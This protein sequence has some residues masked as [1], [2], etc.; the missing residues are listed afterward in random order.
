MN[1]LPGYSKADE[2][3]LAQNFQATEMYLAT[4]RVIVIIPTQE[5]EHIV[6]VIQTAG[7]CCQKEGYQ[8]NF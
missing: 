7:E 8:R 5:F 6:T 2:L 1:L 4:V 3:V